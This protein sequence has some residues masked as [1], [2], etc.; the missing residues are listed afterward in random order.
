MRPKFL[1]LLFAFVSAF[2]VSF[3]AAKTLNEL[4]DW[5]LV[6]AREPRVLVVAL[7]VTLVPLASA[8]GAI[9]MIEKGKT[10]MSQWMR[11]VWMTVLSWGVLF[12]GLVILGLM[13]LQ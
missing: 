6:W 9:W 11:L 4:G 10:G 8:W 2:G 13:R 12:V 7:V 5:A 3:F 1:T